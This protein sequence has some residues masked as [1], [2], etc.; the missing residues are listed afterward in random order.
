[1]YTVYKI[2]V[3][4]VCLYIGHTKDLKKREYQHNYSY[5]KGLKK[6]LYDYLRTLNLFDGKLRLIP[7]A[8]F[9][10]KV[11]AKRYEMYLILQYLFIN[12]LPTIDDTIIKTNLKQKIPNIIDL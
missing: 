7:I 3:D 11:M 4:D 2:E 10:T 12:S 8:N 1:M 9:K 6:D 5:S